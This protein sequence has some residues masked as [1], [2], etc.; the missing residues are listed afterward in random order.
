MTAL[1]RITSL[2]LAALE[3]RVVAADLKGRPDLDLIFD[4]AVKIYRSATLDPAEKAKLA[5]LDYRPITGMRNRPSQRPVPNFQI[6]QKKAAHYLCGAKVDQVILDDLLAP[7]LQ[8]RV[9]V[10]Y[11]SNEHVEECQNLSEIQRI[12]SD[13][14]NPHDVVGIKVVKLLG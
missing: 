13:N 7:K 11:S 1:G 8:W 9:I 6:Q 3:Q 2:D 5:S 12:V 10:T 14:G 4:D